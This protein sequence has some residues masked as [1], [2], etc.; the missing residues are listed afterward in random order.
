MVQSLPGIQCGLSLYKYFYSRYRVFIKYC[1][2]SEFLK[3]FRTVYTRCQCVYTHQAGRKPA[4]QQTWHSSEN[5]KILRKK[6]T[7]FNEHPVYVI[8][9]L[10]CNFLMNP[11]VRLSVSRLVGPRRHIIFCRIL[12]MSSNEENYHFE[13]DLI[14]DV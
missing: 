9:I 5:H 4:L 6:T 7:I 1:V 3:I 2:F 8:K 11:Y 13:F 14:S 10:F 12:S